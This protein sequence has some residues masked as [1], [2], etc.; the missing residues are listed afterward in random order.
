LKRVHWFK[1]QTHKN[2]TCPIK[3]SGKLSGGISGIIISGISIISI[4]I[5]GISITIITSI[6]ISIASLNGNTSIIIIR[7]Q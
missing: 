2:N 7:N 6:N 4:T 5:S 1:L 3:L